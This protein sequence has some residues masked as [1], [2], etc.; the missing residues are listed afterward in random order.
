MP[1]YKRR[2]TFYESFYRAAQ[3][4][5][6]EQELAFYRAMGA[7]A[8]DGEEPE[9]TDPLLLATWETVSNALISGIKA[10]ESG[11]RGGTARASKGNPNPSKGPSKG[12]SKGSENPS[13]G[14]SN[15]IKE[16]E[17]EIKEKEKEMKEKERESKLMS[18]YGEVKHA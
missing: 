17:K 18:F 16:K 3:H 8:F 13:K 6:D 11:S 2:F 4:M 5:S 9:F 10:A 12:A 14:G 1:E 15:Q 7:L